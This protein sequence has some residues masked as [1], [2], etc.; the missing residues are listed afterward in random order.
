MD[1]LS[2]FLIPI[3]HH[4]FLSHHPLQAA[5]AQPRE[6]AASVSNKA[7]AD[8]N[9]HQLGTLPHRS[10]HSLSKKHGP[11]MLLHL[12]RVPVLIV[13]SADAA[14][15]IMKSHDS[16]FSTR[17]KLTMTDKL[18]YR[19][20][21]VAFT[22]YGEFWR[23]IRS[24]C[25]LQLLS[26]KRVQSFRRVREEETSLL[27]DNIR[28]SGSDQVTNLSNMLVLLT[29]DIVCR[30]VL[31]RKLGNRGEGEEFKAMFHET[32]ELLGTFC[33]GDYIPWLAWIDRA[34]GLY[35]KAERL[36]K[37][38]DH[39]FQ[40]VLEERRSKTGAIDDDHSSTDFVDILLQF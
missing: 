36:A 6:K 35:A 10:L 28:K 34:S 15:E 31:G 14:C 21:D 39:F 13:S 7:S 33:V 11:L 40:R 3:I 9:L 24:I 30:A 29:N 19:A 12:G 16:I 23:H 26:A 20:R 17:P 2:H 32:E 18:F 25:V 1:S 37:R 8:R 22:P 4:S 5:A 27:I 38:F